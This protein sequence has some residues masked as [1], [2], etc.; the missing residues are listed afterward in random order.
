MGFID[1]IK[2]LWGLVSSRLGIII[3]SAALLGGGALYHKI[4]AWRHEVALD[5]ATK[6]KEAAIYDLNK[7]KQKV[8]DL[9]KKVQFQRSQL[10]RRQQVQKEVS[11]VDQ[12]EGS[13]DLEYLRR[14][15]QRLHDY[16]NPAASPAP[17][18]S[19]RKRLK[20]PAETGTLQR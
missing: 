15:A 20:P 12:A 19:L 3:L 6:E 7:E 11:D 17:A 13:S 2:L 5:K 4:T 16:K 14:N 8:A 9:E 18:G 1:L 10:S